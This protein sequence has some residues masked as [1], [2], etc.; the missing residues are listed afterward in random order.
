M[1]IKYRCLPS[2]FH[3]VT[4]LHCKADCGHRF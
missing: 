2:R 4:V 3:P 1:N